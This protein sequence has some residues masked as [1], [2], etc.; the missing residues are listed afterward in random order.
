MKTIEDIIKESGYPLQVHLEHEINRTQDTHGWRVLVSEHRWVNPETQDDGF[1]DIIL[2][3]RDYVA[4]RLIA[5]CKRIIGN[6]A[7][8]VPEN[9]PRPVERARILHAHCDNSPHPIYAWPERRLCPISYESAYCV[10]ETGGNRDSRTLEKLSRDV[11]LSLESVARE[12]MRLRSM[13]SIPG[14]DR[15]YIPIIVT[16]ARLRKCIFDPSNVNVSDGRISKS[17]IEEVEFIRFRKS[18]PTAI[19]YTRQPPEDL[20]SANRENQ[21]TVFVVQAK[22]L[23]HFLREFRIEQPV[24]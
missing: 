7:F 9:A 5:E 11:L 12:E 21:R 10:M 18:L 24:V 6:W 15:F 8:L 2:K 3:H 20:E 22:H 13:S 23:V 14:Y 1:I 19:E 16:T 4:I 17:R